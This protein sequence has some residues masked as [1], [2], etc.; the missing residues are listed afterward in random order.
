[1]WELLGHQDVR[2]SEDDGKT[3]MAEEDATELQRP[4]KEEETYEKFRKETESEEPPLSDR[5][6][7]AT[8]R[9]PLPPKDQ[10]R[11]F[12]LVLGPARHRRRPLPVGESDLQVPPTTSHTTHWA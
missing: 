7:P 3:V 9:S 1:M 8:F 6:F 10:I 12:R 4:K 5:R 2:T 11:A